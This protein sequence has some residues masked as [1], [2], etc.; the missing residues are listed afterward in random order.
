MERVKHDVGLASVSPTYKSLTFHEFKD[1]ME[2]S[3]FE[4]D[5]KAAY[6]K[7]G[8]VIKETKDKAKE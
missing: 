8:G 6:L 3:G 1:F 2:K 4:G 5:F 7:I